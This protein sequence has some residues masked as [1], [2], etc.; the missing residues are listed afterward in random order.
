MR[1]HSVRSDLAADPR[2]TAEGAA[3]KERIQFQCEY[4]LSREN[5]ARDAYLVS[6]MDKVNA[7]RV[8]IVRVQTQLLTLRMAGLVRVY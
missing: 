8:A 6:M 2:R 5:L 7:G 3:L 4:Y 1:V